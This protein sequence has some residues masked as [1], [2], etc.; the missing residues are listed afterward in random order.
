MLGRPSQT[1]GLGRRV[2]RW[3]GAAQWLCRRSSIWPWL[4][5]GPPSSQAP[6]PGHAQLRS[7]GPTSPWA[8]QQRPWGLL[9]LCELHVQ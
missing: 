6:V 9:A 1:P 3:A 8:A 7:A 2:G 4:P 5:S